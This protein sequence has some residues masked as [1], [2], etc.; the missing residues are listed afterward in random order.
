MFTVHC[1]GFYSIFSARS[2]R[3]YSIKLSDNSKT[4]RSACSGSAEGRRGTRGGG[5]FLQANEFTVQR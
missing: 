5:F 1:A 2:R 4:H 3:E